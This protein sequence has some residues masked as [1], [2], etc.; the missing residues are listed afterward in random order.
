MNKP[1]LS[2]LCDSRFLED[3][4]RYTEPPAG[5]TI[6]DFGNTAYKRKYEK[7]K[8][9]GHWFS[10]NKMDMDAMYNGQYAETTYGDHMQETYDRIMALPPNCSDNTGR[11]ERI[12]NFAK[13][14]FDADRTIRLLDV[15]SGLGVFPR[16]V[17]DAG[18]DCTAIDPDSNAV[19]H[20]K[21]HVGVNAVQGDF[22]AVKTLDK[23][24]IITFNKVL[25]HVADPVA[26]LNRSKEFLVDD[27]IIYIELPDAEMAEKDGPGREEFFIEHLHVFSSESYS[28]LIK[29]S[30]LNL[31]K[32]ERILE[33]SG[34]YT[35]FGFANLLK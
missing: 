21:E 6:F 28:K 14:R 15:G 7:C 29:N 35:L 3:A 13:N 4:F 10:N 34:K 19:A 5:E 26:M 17:L 25:E 12:K 11:I 30:G 33:P 24:E 23:Y 1:K 22:M 32:L 16:V 31:L 8:L 20:M 9:C 2:C 18:W 27:G